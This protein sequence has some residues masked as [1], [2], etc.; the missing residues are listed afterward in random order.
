M[1]CLHITNMLK[2]CEF[3]SELAEYFLFPSSLTMSNEKV[4]IIQDWIELKKFKNIQFFL[5]FANFYYQFIFNYSDIVISLIYLTQKEILLKFNDSCCNTFNTLKKAFTFTP[6][7][8]HQISNTQLIVETD[9]SNYTLATILSIM[10]K[11]EVYLVTFYSQTFLP[12]ELNYDTYDK[13]LLAIFEAFKIQQH[14]LKG[15]VFS[16]DVIID[17]KNFEYFFITKILTCRQVSMVQ[18]LLKV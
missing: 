14:Y 15:L 13:E 1:T 16:T 9:V 7:L 6:I 8:I 17:H 10:N 12:M 18:V 5:G 3:Y 4:K 2:K 11:N